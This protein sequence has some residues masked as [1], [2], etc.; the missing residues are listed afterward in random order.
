MTDLTTQVDVRST[1]RRTGDE[2]L[3]EPIPAGTEIVG[4]STVATAV[5]REIFGTGH[6]VEW[7]AVVATLGAFEVF[8]L[9]FGLVRAAVDQIPLGPAPAES[10]R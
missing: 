9:G 1:S 6:A 7:V 5:E 2:S 8:K 4:E 10:D 3:T